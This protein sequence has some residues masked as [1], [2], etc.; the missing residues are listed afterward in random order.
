[1]KPYTIIGI[2]EE[3]SF[4]MVGR[5]IS[6]G[7]LSYIK[8]T[9]ERISFIASSILL[10]HSN[11]NV[12]IDILSFDVEKIFF[13]PSTEFK[14][15]SK[16]FDTLVSNSLA[17]APAYV[18]ITVTYGISISGIW[19]IGSLE[20]ENTPNI[21]TATNIRA[22]VI[23]LFIAVLYILIIF[24]FLLYCLGISQYIMVNF[25]VYHHRHYSIYPIFQ[26]YIIYL[27]SLI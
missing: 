6:S 4:K 17:F 14:V 23:G 20:S 1:M 3:L 26:R 5:D 25:I 24:C 9:Y 7:K 2:A 15:F 8:S 21:A 19:S 18:V 10:P 12:T 11:S 27:L 13:N 22:V 16:C